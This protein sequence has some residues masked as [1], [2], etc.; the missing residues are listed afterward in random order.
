MAS[1]HRTTLPVPIADLNRM[2][3]LLAG[4]VLIASIAVFCVVDLTLHRGVIE[5]LL[6]SV[7]P[8]ITA[9]VFIY[10][11][12]YFT[13][14]RVTNLRQ[15]TA[16]Q[17]MVDAIVSGIRSIVPASPAAPAV[18]SSRFEL[19]DPG[20]RAE[21]QVIIQ[22]FLE[23]IYTFSTAFTGNLD[24]RL[25]CHLANKQAGTLHPVCVASGTARNDYDYRSE[26][27]YIGPESRSFVIAKAITQRRVV[28]EDLPVNHREFYPEELKTTIP[29]SLKCVIACPIESY[30]PGTGNGPLGTISIDSTSATCA[31][32]GFTEPTGE[33]STRFDIMLKGCSR[34]LYQVLAM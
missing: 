12:L 31:E 7:I 2:I 34:A 28:A 33:I 26:I 24:L 11:A 22:R 19:P 1:S 20:I 4:T 5:E 16:Q 23:A 30:T 14:S 15:E 29:A 27:P 6:I 32:L 18:E 3:L 13:L 25:Y 17:E 21:Q 8:N 10:I 9:S